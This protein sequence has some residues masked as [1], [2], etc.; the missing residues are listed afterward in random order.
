MNISFIH[1]TTQ[2]WLL[3]GDILVVFTVSAVG[4]ATHGEPVD[5]HI[6]STFIPY[7]IAWLLIAPWLGV[8]QPDV[9]GRALSTWRPALAALLAA[10]MAAWLR[11]FLLGNR[12]I[13]P[14]FVLALGGSSMIAFVIWRLIWSYAQTR[15]SSGHR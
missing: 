4:F 11:G 2:G 8:Y 13:L 5:W 1:K 6:Y 9:T 10:P 12:P 7:T 15:W 3:A 14:V